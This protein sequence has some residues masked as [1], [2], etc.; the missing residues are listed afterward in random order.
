[1]GDRFTFGVTDRGGDV[2]YLYSHWGGADWDKDLKNALYASATHSNSP[3]RGNRIIMS[4]LIG[5]GWD[6][7]TGYAFS[8]NRPMDTEYGYIPVVD[9]NRQ[10]VTFYEYLAD[11][12][13]LGDTILK[14]SLLDYLTCND[15]YG[16]LHLASQELEEARVDVTV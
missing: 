11:K 14:L 4:H 10:T 15:I 16:F 2:L 1:M 5:D 12:G 7:T 9:F 13:I 3:E 6:R 8:I